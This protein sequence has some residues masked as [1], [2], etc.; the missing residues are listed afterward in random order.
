MVVKFPRTKIV[1][2]IFCSI[3]KELDSARLGHDISL[4]NR[5]IFKL[6]IHKC[7]QEAGKTAFGNVVLFLVMDRGWLGFG[8][9]GVATVTFNSGARFGFGT[10]D[11][12]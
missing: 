4:R 6:R 5:V 9:P 8:V 10:G 3:P 11:F 2:C 12:G 7:D 1:E